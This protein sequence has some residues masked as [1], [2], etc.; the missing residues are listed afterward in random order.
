MA[1]TN[2]RGYT[3]QTRR[4]LSL[5]R[6]DGRASPA[7]FGAGRS[8]E[9]FGGGA[10]PEAYGAGQ[11]SPNYTAESGWARDLERFGKIAEGAAEALLAVERRDQTIRAR[12]RLQELRRTAAE[13][14]TTWRD[15]APPDASGFAKSVNER[16]DEWRG[17]QVDGL[18]GV[19]REV[20]EAGLAD[21]ADTLYGRAEEFEASTKREFYKNAISDSVERARNTVFLEPDE[22][23]RELGDLAQTIEDSELPDVA[24]DALVSSAAS[25]LTESLWRRRL[26]DDP[27]NAAAVLISQEIPHL[28]AD[29]RMQLA[30]S[31]E[32]EMRRMESER[33]QAERD[34]RTE[35]RFQ[36][37]EERAAAA[38]TRELLRIQRDEVEASL[39]AGILDGSKTLDDVTK[40]VSARLITGDQARVLTSFATGRAADE[41][42]APLA[43]SLLNRASGGDPTVLG[44]AAEAASKGRITLDQMRQ[45]TNDFQ[46][47]ERQ[48]GVF[49]RED[50][51]LGE[52]NVKR[53]LEEDGGLGLDAG[54]KAEKSFAAIQMYRR[55]IK[56]DPT[57]DPLELAGKVI[58]VWKQG[59]GRMPRPRFLVQQQGAKPDFSASAQATIDAQARG[60]IDERELALQVEALEAMQREIER[61]GKGPWP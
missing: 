1:V 52:E 51:K 13:Q 25:S 21:Y 49:A 53:I 7:A 8:I 59:A 9:S 20:I 5:P 29:S 37:S 42:D 32:S 60:E 31:A 38:E 12:G 54:G 55:H 39:T 11:I 46:E 26:R 24:K 10:G 14:Y 6:L 18:S 48:G 35:R 61:G 58:D 56:D 47:F 27:T 4:P 50:V 41:P 40:A 36:R 3:N 45:V 17:K 28:S 34:A 23:D 43:V 57:Q 44:E 30:A 2:G 33:E 15:Q 19:E 22:F 16:Y